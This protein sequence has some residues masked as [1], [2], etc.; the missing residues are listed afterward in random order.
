[1]KN[2]NMAKGKINKLKILIIF[3]ILIFILFLLILN[4]KHSYILKYKVDG[5]NVVESYNKKD[6][7]YLF[8]LTY[9]N[10]TYEV[11]SL[12][13]YI[14]KRKLINSINIKNSNESTCLSFKSK[15]SLY[16]ICSKEE[17]YYYP[18]KETNFK[19]NSNYNNIKIDNLY[20]NIYFLWN[21]NELV[22]LNNDIYT[23]IKLF[24]KD[25]YNLNLIY[26]TDKYLLISNY[27]DNYKFSKIYLINKDNGK[28]KDFNLRYEVYFDSY[29]LGDYKDK[30]YLYDY[31]SEQEY[32]FDLKEYDIYKTKYGVYKNN[33]WIEVT[34]QKLKNKSVEFTKDSI[35][36]YTLKGDKLYASDKYLV[37]N[38]S[39]NKI[40][41]TNNL[42]IYYLSKDTLYYFN[43]LYGEKAILKYSEWEF[44]NMNMIFI[45]NQN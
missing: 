41:K 25:I 24:N 34:N 43:P 5:V 28:V 26:Q 37:T 19:E 39:V 42:D 30:V 16:D 12:D 6:N 40:V 45:F 18:H 2:K 44:N 35:F 17:E 8:K 20:N 22:Y 9:N 3:L 21:Y 33:K 27:D 14:S 29:F 7:Y 13:K 15:I 23:S 4:N 31:K 10:N 1:M 36:N 32:Y 38:L 11:I